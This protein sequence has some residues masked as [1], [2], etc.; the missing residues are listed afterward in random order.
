MCGVSIVMEKR[1]IVEIGLVAGGWLVIDG[2]IRHRL[3]SCAH[4]RRPT[5]VLDEH[6]I[7]SILKQMAL[8]DYPLLTDLSQ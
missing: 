3:R 6:E 4:N 7:V 1:D 5:L 2:W 8:L